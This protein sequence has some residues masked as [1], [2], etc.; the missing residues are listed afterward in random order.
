MAKGQADDDDAFEI[1]IGHPLKGNAKKI[2][3][4]EKSFS[5]ERLPMMLAETGPAGGT[6][7]CSR[8]ETGDE[9]VVV[10]GL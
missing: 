9:D 8:E 3:R 2:R 4:G 6:S 10:V 5:G 7:S 1:T